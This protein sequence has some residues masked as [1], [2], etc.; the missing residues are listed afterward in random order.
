M[1]E[2]TEFIIITN[3]TLN[4]VSELKKKVLKISIGKV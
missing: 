2:I 3:L 1:N 4:V